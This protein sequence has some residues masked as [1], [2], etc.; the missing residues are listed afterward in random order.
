MRSPKL[1]ISCSLKAIPSLTVMCLAKDCIAR[2][3]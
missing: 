1:R 2:S 3:V